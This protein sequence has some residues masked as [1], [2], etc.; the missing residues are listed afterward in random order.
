MGGRIDQDI[1][2]LNVSVADADCVDVGD[3]PQQ[4][5]CVEL[6]QERR[7]CLSHLEVLLHNSVYCL[8]NKVHHH[9]QI[10]L[11]R[12]LTRCVEGLSHLDAVRVFEHFQNL[13][14]SVLVSLVLENLLDGN[15]FSCFCNCGF[16]DNSERSVANNFLGI[17]C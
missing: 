8:R 7:N 10:D 11:V 13:Q 17:I 1:L 6:N 12:F 15:S 16:E 3:T 9:V 14:L 5:V 2:G 4:L